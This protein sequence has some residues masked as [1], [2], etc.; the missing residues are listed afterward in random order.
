[1]R[2]YEQKIPWTENSKDKHLFEMNLRQKFKIKRGLTLFSVGTQFDQL[3]P[4]KMAPQWK[5]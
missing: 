3:R 1:M 4:Q 5:G 2:Q